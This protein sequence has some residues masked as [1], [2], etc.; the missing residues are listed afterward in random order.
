MCTRY[1][2]SRAGYSAGRRRGESA[3][4]EQ[5]RHVLSMIQAL[6]DRS[7]HTYGSPRIHHALRAAG[8]RVSRRR[9]ARLM[10]EAGLRAGAARLYRR[11][12]GRHGFFTSIPNHQL[13]RFGHGP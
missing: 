7:R 12:P 2:V 10:R 8:P 1:G 13:D 3:R 6:F 11:I 5:D 9:V 4:R